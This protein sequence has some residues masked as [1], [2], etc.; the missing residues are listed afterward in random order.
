MCIRDSIH[1]IA[2]RVIDGDALTAVAQ[3]TVEVEDLV[4]AAGV[5]GRI[6]GHND[7]FARGDGRRRQRAVHAEEG[8]AGQVDGRGP[9]IGQFQELVVVVS[10]LRRGC[11]LYTSRCV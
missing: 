1:R 7:V 2:E 3:A 5:A 11:L 8:V 9:N 10:A 6:V 4:A